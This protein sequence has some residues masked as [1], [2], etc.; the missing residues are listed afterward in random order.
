MTPA[1]DY[2][3]QKMF[4]VWHDMQF[5]VPKARFSTFR[6]KYL[7]ISN[8]NI[9]NIHTRPWNTLKTLLKMQYRTF[10]IISLYKSDLHTFNIILQLTI[11]KS[12]RELN[13]LE[14]ETPSNLSRKRLGR[15]VPTPIGQVAKEK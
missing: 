9:F 6:S 7:S 1:R 8:L 5:P 12:L 10:Q 13:I 15:G 3:R 14:H 4:R 11:L 2:V